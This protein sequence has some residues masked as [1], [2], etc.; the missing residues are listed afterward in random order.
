MS[1]ESLNPG[2]A[3]RIADL[4]LIDN[5]VHGYWTSDVDRIRFENGLNEANTNRWPTSTLDST[6]NSASPYMSALRPLLGL[7]RHVQPDTYFQRRAE[8]S[9]AELARIFLTEAGSP[10]GCSTPG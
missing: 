7:P 3:E 9:A 10:S 2:L 1:P 8:F 4:P 5:H 6:P